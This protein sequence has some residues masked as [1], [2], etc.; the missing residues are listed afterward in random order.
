MKS[1][2]SYVYEREK[3]HNAS[4]YFTLVNCAS[5]LPVYRLGGDLSGERRR[6]GRLVSVSRWW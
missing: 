5:G 4:R 2:P 1:I 6:G 3:Q